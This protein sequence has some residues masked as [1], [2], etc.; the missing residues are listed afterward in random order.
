[1][2]ILSIELV[3]YV[4]I[5]N[6]TGKKRIRFDFS[7]AP[8]ITIRGRNGSGKSTLLRALNPF[9]DDNRDIIQCED[10]AKYISYLKDGKEIDIC[11]KYIYNAKTG[12]KRMMYIVID[13]QDMNP[14]GNITSGREYIMDLFGVDNQFLYLTE[15]SSEDR[16]LAD[17]K[18]MERKRFI[19]SLLDN[20]EAYNGF[21]KILSKKSSVYNTLIKSVSSKIDRL[22]Q[23]MNYPSFEI[24]MAN[25]NKMLASYNKK[26]EDIV[27]EI[28]IMED[29]MRSNREKYR[30]INSITE[31]LSSTQ[32]DYNQK[33]DIVHR[34]S[35]DIDS[36]Q[37]KL[38]VNLKD[39]KDIEDMIESVYKEWV[40]VSSDLKAA[41]ANMS[42]IEDLI[43]KDSVYLDKFSIDGNVEQSIKVIERNLKATQDKMEEIMN[44][45]PQEMRPFMQLDLSNAKYVF[46]TMSQ[47][48][49]NIRQH[50]VVPEVELKNVLHKDIVKE[51]RETEAKAIMYEQKITKPKSIMDLF[52]LLNAKGKSAE[53]IVP[54]ECNVKSC[55]FYVLAKSDMNSISKEYDVYHNEILDLKKK[56]QELDEDEIVRDSFSEAIKVF[57]S[58]PIMVEAYTSKYH[59]DPN[60]DKEE[61]P[62]CISLMANIASACVDIEESRKLYSEYEKLYYK[63]KSTYESMKNSSN[64]IKRVSDRIAEYTK[65][66]NELKEKS[67]SLIQEKELLES[68]N[69]TLNMIKAKRISMNDTTKE[70]MDLYKT[71]NEQN[72]KINDIKS[73]IDTEIESKYMDYKEQADMLKHDITNV[74]YTISKL[75]S[76][77]KLLEEYKREYDNLTKWYDK[78][79]TVKKYTSPTT[80]IQT[81]YMKAFMNNV[82]ITANH[83]LELLFDGR[84]YLTEFIINENEFRIPCYGNG[85]VN[86]DISSMSTSQICMLGMVISFAILYNSSRTY[87]IIKLDEIDGG[88]DSTN[89]AGFATVLSRLAELMNCE[90]CF[91][92]THNEEFTSA[93]Y[94]TM[95]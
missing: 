40:V 12:Y 93:E 80:G 41:T 47:H 6:G 49:Y 46:K 60:E 13:G 50:L 23:G 31:S 1:M 67:D 84:F 88:L 57:V 45:I 87:N 61:N 89:R 8:I 56:L 90:Q 39:S 85:I 95:E 55:P 48:I 27:K 7:D 58:D 38:G 83:L 79:E 86:D 4:G 92:I 82:I 73:S 16:G 30:Q 25:C 11:I 70:C 74:T 76:D 36:L 43:R 63:T 69:V 71:I 14:T 15:I 66:Y 42:D 22:Y 65:K 10:G 37:A 53:Q 77:Q 62:W 35:S 52:D 91:I 28:G 51:R 59:S 2:K 34:L 75:E 54:N 72:A 17:K 81:V 94:I 33:Q 29:T 18:P 19:S 21:Y 32:R 64:E 44:S 3:N 68:K 78:I 20:I 26:Y 5:Y 24:Q 9:P